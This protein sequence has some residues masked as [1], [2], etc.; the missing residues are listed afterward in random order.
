MAK[1]IV[2]SFDGTWNVPDEDPA[3][4]ISS[5]TNV[6]RFHDSITKGVANGREQITHYYSGV[7]TRWFERLIGGAFGIGV[8]RT[9]MRGYK[10]LSLAWDEGDHIFIVGFSRGAYTARALTGVIGRCGLLQRAHAERA[11]DPDGPGLAADDP[12]LGAYQ[13]WTRRGRNSAERQ[14]LQAAAD[15]FS[16]AYCRPVRVTFL[17]VWD[18]VGAL[19]IPGNVFQ[20]FNQSLVEFAD[21]T[22]SPIVDQAFHA[23]AVDEHREEFAA[24]L[25]DRPASAAQ[26]MEQCWFAGDHCDVGG[27]HEMSASAPRVADIPLA[28]MQ[29]KARAAGLALTPTAPDL[30]ACGGEPCHDTYASF[31]G[32]KW[33]ASHPRHLRPIKQTPDG[34]ET[35]HP[36]VL[37]RRVA[38]ATYRPR[39]TGLPPL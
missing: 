11:G 13:H 24:T 8:S 7:G 37:D 29:D 33:A 26:V 6:S 12:V 2:L 4:R 15:A 25:W 19:G 27:G 20:R 14:Q 16:A 22:L 1:R 36:S 34:H 32:G 21:R 28:W 9:M 17:G 30:V 3:D 5:A 10:E 23:M 38:D 35:I 18:T 31:L 39:N